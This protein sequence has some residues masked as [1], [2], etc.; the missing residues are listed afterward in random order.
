MTRFAWCLREC[1]TLAV[2]VA[3]FATLLIVVV[4]A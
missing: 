4:P 3:F 2:L 1:L